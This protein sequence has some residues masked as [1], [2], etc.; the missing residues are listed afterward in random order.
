MYLLFLF[1]LS[2]PIRQR[3]KPVKGDKTMERLLF[4]GGGF[5]R[6]IDSNSKTVVVAHPRKDVDG[7]RHPCKACGS[8]AV[9]FVMVAAMCEPANYHG[10]DSHLYSCDTF[11]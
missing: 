2:S 4:G 9:V 5:V 10:S 7:D 11:F 6:K 8:V 3:L 1:I